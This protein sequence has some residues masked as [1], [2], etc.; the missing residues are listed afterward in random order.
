VHQNVTLS[1]CHDIVKKFLTGR[2]TTNI[3]SLKIIKIH[4]VT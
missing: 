2:S 3:H 4:K 1:S